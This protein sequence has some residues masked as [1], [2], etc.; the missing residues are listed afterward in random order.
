MD[1]ALVTVCGRRT[2]RSRF[3]FPGWVLWVFGCGLAAAG[4]QSAPEPRPAF[5]TAWHQ[6]ASW[7]G[8]GSTQTDWFPIDH[9]NWRIRWETKNAAVGGG[10]LRVEAHS[11]DSGRLLAEPLDVKGNGHGT[12]D[13]G[14]DPHRFYLVVDSSGVDWSLN[15]EEPGAGP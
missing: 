5:A 3:L 12:A 7:S 8:R 1:G 2:A 14:V 13:V 10:R 15:V 11:A 9:F 4:C 6:V